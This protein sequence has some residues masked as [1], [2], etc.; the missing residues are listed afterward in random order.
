M[1]LPYPPPEDVM[2]LNTESEPLFPTPDTACAPPAP[3]V[4]RYVEFVSIV[5]P[6]P[7]RYPPAPPPPAHDA[8]PPPATTNE[9]AVNEDN[10]LNVPDVLNV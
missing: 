3:T 10:G 5:I 2:A 6:E 9:L 1:Y 4:T 8:P 7:V